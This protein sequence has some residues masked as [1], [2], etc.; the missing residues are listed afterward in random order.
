MWV[1]L[2]ASHSSDDER[3][4]RAK[5]RDEIAQKM[6]PQQIAEAQQMAVEWKSKK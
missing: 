6:T 3:E 5:V 4:E 2:S 1:N